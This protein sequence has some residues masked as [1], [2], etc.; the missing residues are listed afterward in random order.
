MDV[1]YPVDSAMFATLPVSA[2]GFTEAEVRFATT[3]GTS[4]A[5]GILELRV[6][7]GK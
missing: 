2:D 5:G 4:Y 6:L 7:E 1:E 3:G